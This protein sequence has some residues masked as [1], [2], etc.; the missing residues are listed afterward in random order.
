[1]KAFW[2]PFVLVLACAATAQ[3]NLPVPELPGTT[4]AGP[5]LTSTNPPAAERPPTEIFS[6][7]AD[8]DLKNRIGV[9]RGHVRVTDPQMKLTCDLLTAQVSTN[10]GRPESIIASCNVRVEGLDDRG[11]AVRVT[12]DKAINIYTVANSTTNDTFTLTGNVYVDSAMFKGT[13]DPII[14]DRVRD[15]IH[16]E[17]QDMQIQPESKRTATNASPVKVPGK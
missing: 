1:M 6:E 4:N 3:T 16:V 5:A 11:R 17:N 10:G 2:F 12:C 7:T 13:G 8:F 14:W 9:Y 15:T